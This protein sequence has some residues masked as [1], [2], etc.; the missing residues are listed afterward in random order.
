MEEL[1]TTQSLHQSTFS[2]RR[3]SS[4]RRGTPVDHSTEGRQKIV[5]HCTSIS[6]RFI[7]F[8][9]INFFIQK[10]Q[11]MQ[12]FMQT[13]YNDWNRERQLEQELA[14]ATAS[15]LPENCED[16]QKNCSSLNVSHLPIIL[17]R[18]VL[19]LLSFNCQKDTFFRKKAY[20]KETYGKIKRL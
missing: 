6:K 5:E 18:L 11:R 12:Q 20:L 4:S 13:A 10:K 9:L 19:A 8:R 3:K 2:E 7:N 1:S 15:I 17:F 16:F 14:T